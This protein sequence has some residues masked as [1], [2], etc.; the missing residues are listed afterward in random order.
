VTHAA[1]DEVDG[2]PSTYA[3]VLRDK[4]FRRF[5]LVTFVSAFVGYAQLEAGW[6]AFARIVGGISTTQIGLA[7][8]ANTAVIVLLQ[9]PIVNRIQGRRRT[10]LLM[11]LA[12]VWATA[13]AV[14]G[15]AGLVGGA[16]AAVL[17]IASAGIFGS[18]ETLQ[19]PV[20][21]AVVNDLASE[22]LRGRYNAT[23]SL[24]FQIAAVLG[25]TS[26]GLL[27]GHGLAA[28][29]IVMLLVGCALLVVLLLG[30]ERRIPA[31]A[32]GVG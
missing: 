14:V 25:P 27:I 19:S 15:I 22:R 17:L 7:F 4:V 20:V 1:V 11:L 12:V 2:T 31:A 16:L 30:L 23:N 3:V 26:A 6:T 24:A 9:L 18:G 13:W 10:R 5:L 21:P 29:Y 32:N 8:A 28:A